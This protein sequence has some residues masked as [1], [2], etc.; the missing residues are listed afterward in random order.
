MLII[1]TSTCIVESRL[2]MIII[3]LELG[4]SSKKLIENRNIVFTERSLEMYITILFHARQVDY[5]ELETCSSIIEK[6]SWQT[7]ICTFMFILLKYQIKYHLQPCYG[8]K[9]I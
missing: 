4:N 6:Y 2:S 9:F 3:N 8:E 5:I 7:I 1:F